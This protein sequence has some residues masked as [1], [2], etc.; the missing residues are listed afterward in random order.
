MRYYYIHNLLSDKCIYKE[1]EKVINM[2]QRKYL[3]LL[4]LVIYKFILELHY[5]YGSAIYFNYLGVYKNFNLGKSIISYICFLYIYF[6]SNRI[7]DKYVKIVYRFFLL[8][9]IIPSISLFAL[10]DYSYSYFVIVLLYWTIMCLLFIF[11]GRVLSK[12]HTTEK[13]YMENSSMINNMLL[14]ISI[15]ATI[16]LF[17]KY[18]RGG[19][20]SILLTYDTRAYFRTRSSSLDTYLIN[21]IGVVL[22]PWNFGI[23]LNHK[24]W[25]RS[26]LSIV[27][28]VMLFFCDGQKAWLFYYPILGIIIFLC[29]KFGIDVMYKCIVC[30]AIFGVVLST[31]LYLFSGDIIIASL[32]DRIFLTQSEVTYFYLDYFKEGN[33]ML[34]SESIFRHFINNRQSESIPVIIAKRY[35]SLARYHS[36]TIGFLGDAYANFGIIGVILYPVLIS[37][38]MFF[39]VSLW[40]NLSLEMGACLSFIF[41]YELDNLPYFTFLLTGGNILFI[42]ILFTL[43]KY[44]KKNICF[45]KNSKYR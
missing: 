25:G 21:W 20:S 10:V 4:L 31:V 2:K 33:Y 42:I 13:L 15:G 22:L 24:K 5:L 12:I 6:L 17:G 41:F 14:L 9:M 29:K 30:I 1:N 26:L 34:L 8:F 39:N 23:S 7:K 38:S 37:F 16:Y 36:A 43:K 19:F 18:Y 32:V 3:E 35:F 28:A 40:K 44:G 27:L 45:V 11:L